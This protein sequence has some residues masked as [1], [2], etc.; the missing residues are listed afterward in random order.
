MAERMGERRR[1]W[2]VAGHPRRLRGIALLA[3]T[4]VCCGPGGEVSRPA[5]GGRHA[6][7]QQ[8]RKSFHEACR[9][10]SEA[11]ARELEAEIAA[12]RREIVNL[13]DLRA[14]ISEQI[15]G[16]RRTVADDP[17]LLREERRLRSRIEALRGELEEDEARLAALRRSGGA[18]EET[19]DL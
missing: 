16:T 13:E 8:G 7:S 18:G 5:S 10:W 15:D 3:L 17:S 6:R 19:G 12:L 4:I 9:A 11:S 1:E 14:S 2:T